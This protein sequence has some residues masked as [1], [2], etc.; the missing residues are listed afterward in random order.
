MYCDTPVGVDTAVQASIEVCAELRVFR[1]EIRAAGVRSSDIFL[2]SLEPYAYV[3]P[4][5][6]DFSYGDETRNAKRLSQSNSFESKSFGLA[7]AGH[8]SQ[9]KEVS[10]YS[11]RPL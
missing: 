11:G 2:A 9:V 7:S 4:V 8:H 1:D 10:W 3:A 5:S 6:T